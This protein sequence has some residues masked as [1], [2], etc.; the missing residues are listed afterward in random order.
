MCT[1]F[2]A[3]KAHPKYRFILIGNRDEFL[4][5]PTETAHFW[6]DKPAIF[7]GRDLQAG[8]TWLALSQNGRFATLT[9]Y[10]DPQ[11]IRKDA[12]SR[13]DLG[14]DFLEN[15]MTPLAYMQSLQAE[16]HLYNGY[17][18][19]TYEKGE[20]AY[21]SNIENAPKS[22]E[23]GIY[24]V[25][26]HLLDTPW[27]KVAE[28]KALFSQLLA[29]NTGVFPLEKAF[30]LLQNTATFPPEKLPKTGV[31]PEW[32][33]LLSALFIISPT[34]GTRVSTVVLED[35]EGNFY[36]EERAYKVENGQIV[37][38][39]RRFNRRFSQIKCL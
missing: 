37:V 1:L 12:P 9:N 2:F 26:N 18:L 27:P 28:N 20:L 3:H 7:G 6:A 38:V 39:S 4:N 19:L 32:E 25:S 5:R 13:G 33:K 15:E 30:S 35:Y 24:A 23:K 8:G 36:M 21:F 16:A 34:Y 14:I 31:P 29:E 10:R 17:N 11:N 22:L